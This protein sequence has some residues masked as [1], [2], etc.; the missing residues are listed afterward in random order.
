LPTLVFVLLKTLIQ[1]AIF[2][3]LFKS[4]ELPSLWTVMM[5]ILAQSSW[6]MIKV[7]YR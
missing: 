3:L 2:V 1:Y 5:L 4:L 7:Y 6:Q